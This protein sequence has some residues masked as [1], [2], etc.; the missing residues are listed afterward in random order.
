M[1]S[2]KQSL[3]CYFFRL[4]RWIDISSTHS[5]S[6]DY[7]SDLRYWFHENFFS[8]FFI[9]SSFIVIYFIPDNNIL[10]WSSLDLKCF[11]FQCNKFHLNL[12]I[13]QRL[14]M[15]MSSSLIQNFLI[16]IIII[17]IININDDFHHYDQCLY[18][19]LIFP[20]LREHSSAFISILL[21]IPRFI[22]SQH[23][24]QQSDYFLSSIF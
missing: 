9:L 2:I 6:H 1:Y 7:N 22:H 20:F 8:N 14:P 23:T 11:I 3:E 21:L 16:I 5:S 10:F 19:S 15:K 4:I 24:V 17:S 13:G 18:F 12:Q